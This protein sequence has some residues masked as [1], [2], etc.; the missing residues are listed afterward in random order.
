MHAREGEA[1]MAYKEQMSKLLFIFGAPKTST[2]TWLSIV[3]HHPDIFLM[4]EAFNNK[5]NAKNWQYYVKDI[6]ACPNIGKNTTIPQIFDSIYNRI[7]KE[8]KYFGVKWA[9]CQTIPLIEQY[10]SEIAKAKV[11]FTV[12]DVRTWLCHKTIIN[13]WKLVNE[14]RATIKVREYVYFYI[15]SFLLQ[16]CY[17]ATLDNFIKDNGKE[18]ENIGDW[19]GLKDLTTH[20]NEWWNK[21]GEYADP[22]KQL[23]K[24]WYPR[25]GTRRESSFAKPTQ[26][27]ITYVLKDN[28]MWEKLL[29]VFDKYY[30]CPDGNFSVEEIKK[31]LKYVK[32]VKLPEFKLGDCYESYTTRGV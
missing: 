17:R 9:T 11:I 5:K 18:I 3:N 24:W 14:P 23:H 2:S 12:R 6:G 20:S 27:D 31:D 4:S 25:E 15:R 21:T 22:F 19:L 10:L 13:R 28:I 32:D 29:P 1:K 30:T 7:D 16:D 26:E 8:Y